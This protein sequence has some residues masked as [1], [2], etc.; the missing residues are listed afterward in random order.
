M[1]A[2]TE[3]FEDLI[4]PY[5]PKM[6]KTVLLPFKDR[7]VYDGLLRAFFRPIEECE[8]SVAHEPMDMTVIY[9]VVAGGSACTGCPPRGSVRPS[10][11]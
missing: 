1:V 2:L 9:R 5:L 7:I 11:S 4:G 3:P 10:R 8:D 6:T